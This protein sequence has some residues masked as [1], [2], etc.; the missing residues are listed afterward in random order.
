[1]I[2]I[3]AASASA[4]YEQVRAQ[5]AA[6]IVDGTLAVGSRLPTVR[7]LATELSLA[8]NT[9]AKAYLELEQAGL[10]ESRGRA[11]T[12]VAATGDRVRTQVRDAARRYAELATGLG[13]TPDESLAIVTAALTD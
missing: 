5:L 3:D 2:R 12:F 9:V 8:P 13:L 6:Q 1:M 7:G 4:P 11:G 10:T